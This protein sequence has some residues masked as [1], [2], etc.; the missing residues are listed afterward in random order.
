MEVQYQ[1]DTNDYY[2][3]QQQVCRSVVRD[4][5][6]HFV[7]M[8]LGGIFGFRL[9]LGTIAI[10]KFYDIYRFFDFSEL[11]WGL[12]I[13]VLGIFSF[14]LGV[15]AYNHALKRRMFNSNGPYRSTHK[16]ILDD[17]NLAVV[18]KHNNYIFIW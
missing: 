13:I 9:A 11:N 4:S 12:G 6:W 18:V 1:P 17:D 3:A 16:I 2:A 10:G 7:P 15:C 14:N 8:L 5:F